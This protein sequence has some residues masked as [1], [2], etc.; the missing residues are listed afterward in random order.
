MN[1]PFSSSRRLNSA[2]HCK[3][4]AGA[5]DMSLPD[6]ATGSLNAACDG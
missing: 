4:D 6:A 2:W 1:K 3:S 5:L